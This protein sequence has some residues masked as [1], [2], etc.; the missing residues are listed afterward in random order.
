MAM[1]F[2]PVVLALLCSAIA[3]TAW[4]GHVDV[5]FDAKASYTDAGITPRQRE[6]HLAAL[7]GHLKAL[8]ERRL[9]DDRWLSI[10]LLDL[11]LA[12]TTRP[13]TRTGTELRIVRGGADGPHIE[14]RYSL[15][16]G[17]RTIAAGRETLFDAGLPRLDPFRDSGGGDPL[18]QEKI[19]LDHWFEERFGAESST[20]R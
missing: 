13:V 19:L 20:P 17:S 18:R 8:G 16:D 4:A 11:D 14:L 6:Q 1:P 12:G 7:A 3:G 2:R 10:E 5:S 15:R 9:P